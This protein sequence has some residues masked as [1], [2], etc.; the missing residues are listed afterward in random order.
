MRTRRQ[1]MA[2]SNAA[3]RGASVATNRN[4]AVLKRGIPAKPGNPGEVIG[5]ESIQGTRYVRYRAAEGTWVSASLAQQGYD[6]RY[7]KEVSYG[8]KLGVVLGPDGIPL[9]SVDKIQPGQEY[10]IPIGTDV[11]FEDHEVLGYRTPATRAGAKPWQ[12][13]GSSRAIKHALLKGSKY[14]YG[15]FELTGPEPPSKL[16]RDA[17]AFWLGLHQQEI[18]AAETK[19]RVSRIAIAGIIA[20]EAL[21]NPQPRLRGK[22]VGPGK[23]HLE[24]DKGHYSW[25]EVVEGTGRVKELPPIMRKYV[26]AR[27]EVSIDYI[28]AI[29]D[30]E[31]SVAEAKGW[32]IR[33]NPEI[34]S[35]AYHNSWPDEWIRFIERKPQTEPFEIIPGEM[36]QWIL[37]N[38]AYLR[39]AIGGPATFQ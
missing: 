35:Q 2:A 23:I 18:V 38:E 3:A 28:G 15:S 36:G 14:R 7:G 24:A 33:N 19:W 8:A 29:L 39:K 21:Q 12:E 31:A 17:V 11:Q 1:D 6:K 32:N 13:K 37:E 10:L 20:W 26:L 34:L 4:R 9:R 5:Q 27:P 30:F 16:P 22:S 25:P